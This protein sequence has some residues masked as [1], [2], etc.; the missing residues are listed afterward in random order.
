MF[1][2]LNVFCY[3][4]GFITEATS[5]AGV[6]TLIGRCYRLQEHMFYVSWFFIRHY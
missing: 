4:E 3:R 6:Y 2:S 1:R 5:S